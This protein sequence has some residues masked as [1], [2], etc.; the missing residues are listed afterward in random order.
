MKILSQDNQKQHFLD[1]N[2][3]EEQKKKKLFTKSRRSGNTR[4]LP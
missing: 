3:L 4:N 1:L 2:S